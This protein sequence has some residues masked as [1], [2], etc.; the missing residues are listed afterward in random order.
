MT[1]RRRIWDRLSDDDGDDGGGCDD[2]DRAATEP[3]DIES[4]RTTLTT[5]TTNVADNDNAGH[6]RRI[7]DDYDADQ[8]DDADAVTAAATATNE[9][10]PPAAAIAPSASAAAASIHTRIVEMRRELSTKSKHL[11][12]IQG[13][14][15]RAKLS[16]RQRLEDL[17]NALD[18]RRKQ[19][20]ERHDA[21][22]AE[23]RRLLSTV[24]RD[25]ASM[26]DRTEALSGEIR[27]VVESR[28]R[29]C[30]TLQISGQRELTKK[31]REWEGTEKRRLAQLLAER[32]EEMKREAAKSLEPKLGAILKRIKKEKQALRERL[33]METAELRNRL[34]AENEARAEVEMDTIRKE[35]ETKRQQIDDA[36]QERLAQIS[37]KHSDEMERVR[38]ASTGSLYGEGA[39]EANL[40]RREEDH[41]KALENIRTQEARDVGTITER[42]QRTTDELREDHKTTLE[43]EHS[44]FQSSL[45]AWKLQREKEIETESKTLER[46]DIAKMQQK[47]DDDIARV[48][49][50]LGEE[51]TEKKKV[52]R[53]EA[54]ATMSAVEDS[55]T[56]EMRSA[57]RENETAASQDRGAKEERDKLSKTVDDLEARLSATR[58]E[59]A[60]TEKSASQAKTNAE[61]IEAKMK[62]EAESAREMA[63]AAIDTTKMELSSLESSLRYRQE[64]EK[65]NNDRCSK[66][67][68]DQSA[69]HAAEVETVKT[70]IKDLLKRKEAKVEGATALL[71]EKKEEFQS[72]EQS[73]EEARKLL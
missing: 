53:D 29:L 43:A 67:E 7:W 27:Q 32:S 26:T 66:A 5:T 38:G 61:A 36:M 37:L 6:R 48:V 68:D 34:E 63:K 16:N 51:A 22:V 58:L 65:E 62:S 12:R 9:N 3:K 44:R 50:K 19:L 52:L 59:A 60:D 70:R 64:E 45:D 13:D 21:S 20:Q 25:C 1:P 49:S 56:L 2:G 14:L 40:V 17:Q 18:E 23:Q 35:F 46:E 72:L 69:Q 57:R 42:H 31:R 8:A 39:L 41:M 47:V 55:L 11:R 71:Q 54:D 4:S 28:E 24:Q 15:V 73:V 33:T 10:Q 30:R